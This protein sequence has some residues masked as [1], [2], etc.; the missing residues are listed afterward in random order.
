MELWMAGILR[1]CRVLVGRD[2]RPRDVT[3]IHRRNRPPG[4]LEAFFGCRIEFGADADR[5]VFPAEVRH[6]PIVSSD[7]YLNKALIAYFEDAV[8][9]R[10]SR[11]ETLRTRIENVVAPRLPHGNVR[12]GDVAN[13]LGMSRRTF[14]RRL[15]VERLTFGGIVDDLRRDL[16]NRYL[17]DG[18]LSISRIAWLLG[19]QEVS[20]FTHAFR[21]WSGVTPTSARRRMEEILPA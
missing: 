17:R 14:T 7:P 16:A 8:A 11:V 4:E 20:A 18:D 9:H 3:M 1:L 6:A 2:L 13:L 10:G 12:A 15:A 5:L 19:Y 21:R